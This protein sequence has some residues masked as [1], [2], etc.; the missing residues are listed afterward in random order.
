MNILK[1]W[2]HPDTVSGPGLLGPRYVITA[3][4]LLNILVSCVFLLFNY[5]TQASQTSN[6][7]QLIA[8]VTTLVCLR[9]FRSHRP[10]AHVFLG[11]GLFNA[12][13]LVL[14]FANFPYTVLMW[15]PV[16]TILSVFVVGSIAGGL[17]SLATNTCVALVVLFGRRWSVNTLDTSSF[18][19]PVMAVITLYFTG[20]TAFMASMFFAQSIRYLV[21]LQQKHNE[22][23]QQQNQ[24]IQAYAQ[25]KA[26]LVSVVAHDIATPLMIILYSTEAAK[27]KLSQTDYYLERIQKAA[28]IIQEIIRS[29]RGFQTLEAGSLEMKLEAVD[30]DQVINRLNFTFE[31]KLQEKSLSLTWIKPPGEPLL[32]LADEKTLNNSVLSNLISNAIKFSHPGQ[33]ILLT[34]QVIGDFVEL[35]IQDFGVG[36]AE[37]RMKSLFAKQRTISRPGTLGEQGRGLGLAIC[38]AFV[39]KYGGSMQVE[40]IEAGPGV[41]RHGTSFILRLRRASDQIQRVDLEH[42]ITDHSDSHFT[43]NPHSNLDPGFRPHP[44]VSNP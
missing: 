11:T 39:E 37:D 4:S 15:M 12:C 29:V 3:I 30:L 25:D 34:A 40:S 41:E 42:P 2:Q 24:T 22:E 5:H 6:L 14:T 27:K 10:G 9:R 32:I 21:H 33:N 7:V 35:R 36:M 23:L 13:T 20:I 8:S 43:Q 28:Q 1:V 18:N 26:M 19:W 16:Y 31:E 38:K 44:N 17:W